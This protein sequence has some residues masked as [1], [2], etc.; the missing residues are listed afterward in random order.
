M[1]KT[2]L[3]LFLSI[4]FFQAQAQIEN[5]NQKGAEIAKKI[6]EAH[7]INQWDDVEELH[8]S[9]NIAT[10]T[11]LGQRKWIWKPKK[12]SIT[13]I[14]DTSEKIHYSRKAMDSVIQKIDRGFINDK[15]WL[16]LPFNLVWDTG[17][18]FTYKEK[19]LAPINKKSMQQLTITYNAESGGYTPGD[20][21]DLFFEDDFVLK[22]WIFRKGNATAP[23]MTTT[24][25][26]Y[27]SY[28]GIKIAKMHRIADSNRKVYFSDI[29]IR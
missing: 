9:F 18:E 26:D 5:T 14:K 3:I 4:F 21:Y 28:K 2:V 11:L 15:F 13:L 10:D 20:A 27:D 12:D 23:S 7:G 29:L 1:K 25:E 16:L 22:E 6:A 17:L 24:C 8:Y 19:T